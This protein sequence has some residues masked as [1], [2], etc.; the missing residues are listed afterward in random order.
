MMRKGSGGGGGEVIVTAQKLG[1]EIWV[2]CRIWKILQK[3]FWWDFSHRCPLSLH[4][5]T[6]CSALCA[7]W[8]GALRSALAP[9]GRA[10]ALSWKESLS[11]CSGQQSRTVS[12]SRSHGAC[13]WEHPQEEGCS[14]WDSASPS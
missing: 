8:G 3:N 12:K 4:F 14:G 11:G 1:R 2:K 10:E 7:V 5:S 6:A 13:H 9:S